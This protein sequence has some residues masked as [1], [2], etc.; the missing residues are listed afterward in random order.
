MPKER[1]RK[2][3][4]PS[5]VVISVDTGKTELDYQQPR[6]AEPRVH[7]RSQG[8]PS[9][10]RPWQDSEDDESTAVHITRKPMGQIPL[11]A[12]IE[13]PALKDEPPLESHLKPGQ[14]RMSLPSPKSISDLTYSS[15][16]AAVPHGSTSAC[17]GLGYPR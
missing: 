6:N 13:K 12:L 11:P 2:R 3:R 10:K 15:S 1:P 5:G 16:D 4:K 9:G 8:K 14:H 17:M 7:P